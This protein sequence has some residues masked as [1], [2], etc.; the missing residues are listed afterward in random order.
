MAHLVCM[1]CIMIIMY[2]YMTLFAI[3]VPILKPWVWTN[4]IW[5][6]LFFWMQKSHH[7]TRTLQRLGTH[8]YRNKPKTLKHGILHL[9]FS[10][11]RDVSLTSS[12]PWKMGVW[13]QRRL[14]SFGKPDWNLQGRTVSLRE[15]SCS[16][17][18][19]TSGVAVT[20]KLCKPAGI[21]KWEPEGR[22]IFLLKMGMF[23]GTG[24][25]TRE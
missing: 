23:H 9:K 25:F 4:C 7:S 8:G 2:I 12:R 10:P 5:F 3:E 16:L 11:C 24:G 14:F 19:P 6:H 21:K 13:P 1:I 20:W 17:E 15:G 22:C 18:F